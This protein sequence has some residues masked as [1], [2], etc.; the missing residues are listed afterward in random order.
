MKIVKELGKR[1]IEVGKAILAESLEGYHV[2]THA[3]VLT[4]CVFGPKFELNSP[5]KPTK[6]ASEK[7]KNHPLEKTITGKNALL[8]EIGKQAAV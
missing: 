3:K 7:N 1:L 5:R 8:D 6:T 2:T 4:H